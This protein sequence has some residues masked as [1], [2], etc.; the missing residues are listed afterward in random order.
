[1]CKSID[2]KETEFF[3]ARGKSLKKIFLLLLFVATS[4]SSFKEIWLGR[5][6][7]LGKTEGNFNSNYVNE[8]PHTKFNYLF[9][10]NLSQI[11]KKKYSEVAT[12]P[13]INTINAADW[14]L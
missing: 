8:A 5:L 9:P 3:F 6:L 2:K 13:M 11:L 12:P 14:A 7:L 10:F 4:L 1:M